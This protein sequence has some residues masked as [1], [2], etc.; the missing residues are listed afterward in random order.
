MFSGMFFFNAGGWLLCWWTY[1]N[2]LLGFMYGFIASAWKVQGHIKEVHGLFIC[3]NCDLETMRF[4]KHCV[5]QDL[6]QT[7]TQAQLLVHAE[8]E[9]HYLNP[10]QKDPFT[11][12]CNTGTHTTTRTNVQLP[13]E[14]WMPAWRQM[15]S[16][17]CGISSVCGLLKRQMNHTLDWLRTLKT[18]TEITWPH[19][20]TQTEETRLN[21]QSTYG[22][23]KMRENHFVCNG[24]CLR[25]AHRMIIWAR[26]ATCASK[27][28]FLL[29]VET[30]YVHWTKE[31]N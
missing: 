15:P 22:P 31:T 11:R 16:G 13:K 9:N 23:W 14:T 19:F 7:H 28:I 6:Q 2:L 25:P 18:D 8:Y 27:K 17:K 24:K 12:H 20:D 26:N 4:E 10:Q 29:F 1:S 3:F 21:C 5:A 30:I